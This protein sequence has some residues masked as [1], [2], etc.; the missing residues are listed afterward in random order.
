MARGRV[1]DGVQVE[2]ISPSVKPVWQ[3]LASE[4]EMQQADL[5][6]GQRSN[7]QAHVSACDYGP[8][9]VSVDRWDMNAE[10]STWPEWARSPTPQ[11][12]PK[13]NER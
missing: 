7:C 11:S 8:V 10:F 4:M 9:K 1:S 5:R 13:Q 12:H 6:S 2:R 3:M